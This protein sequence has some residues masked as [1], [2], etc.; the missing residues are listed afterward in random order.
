[1]AKSTALKDAIAAALVA[2]AA[3][4]RPTYAPVRNVAYRHV[5][6]TARAEPDVGSSSHRN[7]W[8]GPPILGDPA[9]QGSA[10]TY[11]DC[12]FTMSVALNLAGLSLDQRFEAVE[13]ESLFL[14]ATINQLPAVSGARKHRAT[15]V[16]PTAEDPSWEDVTL[17]FSITLLAAE[18]NP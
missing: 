18:A 3:G 6:A 9:G 4:A 5:G 2:L 14:L 12:T 17:E 8:F 1:M 13:A 7:F 15:G 10:V 16:T 11:Y